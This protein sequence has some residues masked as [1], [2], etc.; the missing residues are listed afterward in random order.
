MPKMNRRSIRL[1]RT[2]L[3]LVAGC[4]LLCTPGVH[5]QD[6]ASRTVR[7]FGAAGDGTTDDTGAFQRAVDAAQGA[8]RLPAGRYRITR[9]VVI[10]LDRVGPASVVGDGTATVVM[11]GAGPAFRFIGTHGGTAAPETVKPNVWLRQRT[12]LVDGFEIVGAH[13]K[14]L[15]VEFQGTMQATITRLV[16][17]RTLHAIRLTGRNRNVIISECH[18]YENRGAGVLM[19]K[20]NLHQVN[21]SNS[22]ISYNG[23]GGIVVRESEIRNLQI[24]TCDIEGNMDPDGP[25][26][27]NVLLDV[28]RGSMREGAIVGCT[29]QHNHTSPGSANIRL[30]G[31]AAEPLK[32]GYFSIS[33]NALSDVMVNIHLKHARG[34]SITGNS[35]WKG[36]EHDLL[37]EGSSNIVVGP[38]LFDRNPDYRPADSFNGI[39]FLDSQDCTLSGVHLNG[40]LQKG[41]ALLLR[42]CRRINITGATILNFRDAGVW[43]D[44]TQHS[45]LS[46]SLIQASG[47][48]PVAVRVTGGRSN[49]IAGNLLA[50]EAAIESG[51]AWVE[52]N[53]PQ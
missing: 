5:A 21:I 37:V 27:A 10:D 41:A 33:D 6:A 49:M 35:L 17:R 8:V 1:T 23:G 12:P 13:P 32:A 34:V 52:G 4:G 53:H 19:E 38:N 15:G 18:L 48:S 42:G 40:S 50:G 7:D 9:P 47:D 43:F 36:F 31:R 39:V 30:L 28:R 2:A 24:G 22:H 51:T 46:D 25:P 16:V 29:I 20:L 45:R 26:T 11:D 3:A 44:R 14:A